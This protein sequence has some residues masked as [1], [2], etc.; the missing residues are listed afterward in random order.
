MSQQDKDKKINRRDF[1]KIV[2]ITSAA[3]SA[4]FVCCNVNGEKVLGNNA[5]TDVPTDTMTFRTF[6]GL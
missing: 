4:A 5:S 6:P 1:I 2:G 3:T